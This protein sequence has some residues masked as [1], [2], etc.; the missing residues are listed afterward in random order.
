LAVGCLSGAIYVYKVDLKNIGEQICHYEIP[1]A[2][3]KSQVQAIKVDSSRGG[4]LGYVASVG[5]NKYL[6][7][8]DITEKTQKCTQSL[9]K[10]RPSTMEFNQESGILAVG[11][12]KGGIFVFN[13]NS[14]EVRI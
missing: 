2:H 14:L 5:E 3:P 12:R 7:V 8:H 13:L 10:S 1:N 9:G 11:N 6:A 4:E